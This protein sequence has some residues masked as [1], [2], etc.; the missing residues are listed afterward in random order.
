MEAVYSDSIG[1]IGGFILSDGSEIH[2][3][4]DDIGSP[5]KC[6]TINSEMQETFTTNIDLDEIPLGTSYA[7]CPNDNCWLYMLD[8]GEYYR[9]S[10][11]RVL[12]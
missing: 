9:A 8:N 4:Q 3:T 2:L 7:W 12:S 5:H 6:S 10:L 11:L 1:T